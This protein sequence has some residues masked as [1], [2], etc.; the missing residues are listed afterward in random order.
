MTRSTTFTLALFFAWIS[1]G[2]VELNGAPY[3][4]DVW[5]AKEWPTAAAEDVA[6]DIGRLQEARDYALT[7]G[8]SGYITRHGKLVLSWGDARRRY[9]LKSTTKSFGATA[10][11]IA[12]KDGKILLGDNATKHHPGLGSEPSANKKTG[13]LEKITIQH[14]ATQTAGFEKA[15]GYEKL[16][17]EPGKIC[18]DCEPVEPVR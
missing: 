6:L 15:G 5:P 18:S 12:I 11:A 4:K 13:W 14:L 8:G 17:F 10:L 3:G 2:L 16:V 1:I 9:D 7:T